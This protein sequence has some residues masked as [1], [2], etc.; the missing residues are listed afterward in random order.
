MVEERNA[1]RALPTEEKMLHLRGLAAGLE[2]ELEALRGSLARLEELTSFEIGH[3]WLVAMPPQAAMIQGLE[4]AIAHLQTL[5][6]RVY[7][8]IDDL[9]FDGTDSDTAGTG[10]A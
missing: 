10:G 9:T 4:V 2:Q 5:L 6:G 1:W 7:S 3:F 8:E